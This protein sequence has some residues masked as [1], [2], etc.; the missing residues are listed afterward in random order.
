MAYHRRGNSYL[1]CFYPAIEALGVKVYEGEFS[2][3]WLL[4]HLRNIDYIHLHWPSFFYNVPQRSKCLRNFALFLFL[5]TLARWRGARIIWTVHNLY[6]HDSC[7]VPQLDV[8]TRRVLVGMGARFF[9]HGASARAAVLREFP[10]LA[11]RT[12]QIEHG[13]WIDYYPDTISCNAA[14]SRLGLTEGEFVFL[15][16]GLCKPYKN[17]EGLIQAFEHLPGNP[18]LI[19]AGQ[20]Q[21]ANYEVTIRAAITRSRSRIVLH[22]G[23]VRHEDMQVYLRACNVVATPYNEVLSSGSAILALSFGRPVV[24]PAIGCL[25]DL[26]VEGCGFLYDPS[27]SGG[28]R[29]S[30]LL[31]ME[32][33]FDEAHILAEALKLNWRESARIVLNS[34]ATLRGSKDIDEK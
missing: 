29:D 26:I 25:K 13:H 7:V 16:I 24:A 32:A 11:G 19:I 4:K 21:D 22:S 6:P 33:T 27:R 5:L 31:A 18:A 23:F 2:G 12:V 15:F 14:R 9:I 1:D 8:L 17:L 30:M 34:L 20:F 28:L 3:K 10:S